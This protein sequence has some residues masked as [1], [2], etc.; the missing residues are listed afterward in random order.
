MDVTAKYENMQKKLTVLEYLSQSL[1]SLTA[2]LT[3]KYIGIYIPSN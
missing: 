2:T 3:L 1:A